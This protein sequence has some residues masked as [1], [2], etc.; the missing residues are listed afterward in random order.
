ML[1]VCTFN[2]FFSLLWTE[3]AVKGLPPKV[4]AWVLLLLL[5]LLLIINSLFIKL[6]N[7]TV[8]TLQ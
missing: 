1:N 6:L 2:V 8:L 3:V 4:N 7:Y 5:L